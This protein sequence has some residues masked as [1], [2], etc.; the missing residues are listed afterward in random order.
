MFTA[1]YANILAV[2]DFDDKLKE[3]VTYAIKNGRKEATMRIYYEDWY[4][5]KIVEMLKERNFKVYDDDFYVI[6]KADIQFYWS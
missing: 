5:D 4:A 2:D 3:V 6:D 1:E